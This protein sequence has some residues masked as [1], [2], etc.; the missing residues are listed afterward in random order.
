VTGDDGGHVLVVDRAGERRRVSTHFASLGGLAWSPKG[1]EVWFGGARSGSLLGLQAATLQ[2]RE[3]TI[4][5]T[6]SRM[7]LHDIDASGRALLDAGTTRIGV[8][9]GDASGK[10]CELSWLDSTSAVQMTRDGS[11]VL[12]VES[13]DG[14]GSDYAIYLRPADASPPVRLGSGR[15]TSLS[16]DGR[17]VL[18]IP[19]RGSGHIE[20]IPTGAGQRR[21]LKHDGFSRYDW[22]GFLGKSARILFVG[23]KGDS[24]KWEAYVQDL[25]DAA[26][27]RHVGSFTTKRGVISVD[28]KK[29]V[30]WCPSGQC[31]LDLET[32]EE[33]PVP[34]LGGD[35]PLF[36]D[37]D[38]RHLFVRYARP[39]PASVSR[40]DVT[41][42]QKTPWRELLPPDSVGVQGVPDI[43]GTPDGKAYAYSYYR[44]LSELFVVE[45]LR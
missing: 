2:A 20:L 8:R 18:A 16:P 1:D 11:R 21:I 40:L 9:Y 28:G 6:G 17:W 34:G 22:A 14:G 37:Q 25:D 32:L 31:V 5:Q 19:I 36:W 45:G 23:M 41:T 44:R 12:L 15:A 29:I 42:G 39:V 13:G 30:K 3:R 38:G 10:E 27:P 7:I 26:P 24:G 35:V 33:K 43:I 4:L